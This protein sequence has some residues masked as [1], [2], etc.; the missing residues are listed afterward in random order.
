M[1]VNRYAKIIVK[2]QV[3]FRVSDQQITENVSKKRA[4]QTSPANNMTKAVSI[5]WQPLIEAEKEKK[6]F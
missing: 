5:Y 1:E 4:F 6:S 2:F 3:S